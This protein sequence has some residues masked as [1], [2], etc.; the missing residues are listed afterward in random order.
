MSGSDE[1]QRHASGNAVARRSL[2]DLL[3]TETKD[4]GSFQFAVPESSAVADLADQW[5]QV[6]ELMLHQLTATLNGFCSKYFDH[7]HSEPSLDSCG[8]VDPGGSSFTLKAEF[9]DS[10]AFAVAR[11]N[12]QTMAKAV[13]SVRDIRPEV[14]F[15]SEILK[16]LYRASMPFDAGAFA[17]TV[18]EWVEALRR[19]AVWV[20]LQAP[21]SGIPQEVHGITLAMIN[22]VRQNVRGKEDI[23]AKRLVSDLGT[24]ATANL[25]LRVL[26]ALG[27]FNGFDR[28]PTQS[29][30]EKVRAIITQLRLAPP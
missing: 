6:P 26:E 27:E 1:T 21:T 5:L 24:R 25:S 3:N 7:E 12:L 17:K 2:D 29:V 11:V 10:L 14:P 20:K 16:S 4:Q 30:A 19:L 9:T 8:D 28:S 22:S 15:T 18:T 13:E 23:R